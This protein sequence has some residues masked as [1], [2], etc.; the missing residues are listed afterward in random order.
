MKKSFEKFEK[1]EIF[2]NKNLLISVLCISFFWQRWME[3]IK[4]SWA[5][6]NFKVKWK[7]LIENS[8]DVLPVKITRVENKQLAEN[9][10]K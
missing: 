9:N 7:L 8:A 4:K 6:S 3:Q 5:I 2:Q 1:I 10:K